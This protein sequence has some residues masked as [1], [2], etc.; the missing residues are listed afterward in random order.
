MGIRKKLSGIRDYLLIIRRYRNWIE[1]LNKKYRKQ[2]IDRVILRNKVQ[3]DAPKNHPFLLGMTNETFFEKVHTP[4]GLPIEANDVVVDIGANIGIVTLFAA[5]RTKNEVYAF[6]PSP[7]NCK[8][9]N[10]NILKN[11]LRNVKI[12]NVAVGD[13]T[14]EHTRLYLGDSVGH[15]ILEAEL[16]A[17]E[18]STDNYIDIPSVTLPYIIDKIVANEIDFLKIDCEGC[19]GLIFMSTP[20][21]YLRRIGKIVVEFH[22]TSSPLKHEAIQRL[23]EKAGF[24]TRLFWGFGKNSPYG[25]LYGERGN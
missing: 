6:E 24:K 8:F 5:L 19:E 9:I 12:N 25:Y 23:M 15:S 2:V 22:D 10:R 14:E 1:I 11:D 13:R 17:S 21:E 16:L 7:E 4:F 18:C 20:I 3:I